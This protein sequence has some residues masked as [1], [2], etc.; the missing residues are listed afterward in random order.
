MAQ[1]IA[2]GVA[3]GCVYALVGLAF[4]L[5]YN[6]SGGLNFSQGEFVM[7]GAFSLVTTT[8]VMPYWLAVIACAACIGGLSW[9]FQRALFYPLKD[10]SYLHFVI[11]TIGFSILARN[12]AII[13]WGPNPLTAPAMTSL[14]VVSFGS[15][16]LSPQNLIIIGF[17]A[18]LLALQYLMFFH[19]DLG[20][21]LRATAQNA[22]MAQ[23]LGIR[24]RRMM[25]IT[26]VMSGV[27]AGLAGVLLAPIF[28]VDSDMGGAVLLKSFI[29]VVIGGFGS[30]PGVVI[31]GIGIGMVEIF[32]AI[33]VSSV[34]KDAICIA[35]L[36]LFLIAFPRGLLGE[37]VSE[38]G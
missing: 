11:V 9:A 23:L 38:R 6:A 27:I 14:D 36:I 13:I 16:A 15:V 21:R 17:T 37:A 3:M 18:L 24:P 28:L 29:A 10:R 32:A 22:T 33:Y 26:F 8:A 4:I 34:Y 35:I 2:S 20:R 1:I 5:I 25:G 30:I 31:G 19:T 12:L 7:L